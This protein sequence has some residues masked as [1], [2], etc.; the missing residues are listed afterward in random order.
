LYD[1][2]RKEY[3]ANQ[4]E[5]RD[6]ISRL[7]VADEDYCTSSEYVLQLANRA[8]DFFLSS[9]AGGKTTTYST[10]TSEPDFRGEFLK[11]SLILPE[12]LPP[13]L[14]FKPGESMRSQWPH[15]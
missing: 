2:K 10:D 14:E 15:R 8:Y 11:I 3:R 7:D 4:E 12:K 5:T 9:E 1:K 13:L 6:K